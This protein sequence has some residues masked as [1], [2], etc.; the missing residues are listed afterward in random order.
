MMMQ[1]RERERDSGDI[2]FPVFWSKSYGI[3]FPIRAMDRSQRERET[4]AAVFWP[5]DEDGVDGDAGGADGSGSGLRSAGSQVSR[6]VHQWWCLVRWIFSTAV[7][8]AYACSSTNSPV[9]PFHF[10]VRFVN[11]VNCVPYWSDLVRLEMVRP[12]QRKKNWFKSGFVLSIEI[13]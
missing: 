8:A 1:R 4:A 5:D 12:G 9:T 2:L 3:L 10:R 11:Q 7:A 6:L 13:F